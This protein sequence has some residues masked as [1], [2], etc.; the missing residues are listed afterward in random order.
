MYMSIDCP[1]DA[2]TCSSSQSL[3]AYL[4]LVE[5]LSRSGMEITHL[6]DENPLI[7]ESRL[8]GKHL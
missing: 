2:G 3:S 4:P 7:I 1:R 6:T 8:A 5:A